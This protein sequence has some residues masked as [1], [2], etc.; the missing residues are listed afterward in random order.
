VVVKRQGAEKLIPENS[1]FSTYPQRENYLLARAYWVQEGYPLAILEETARSFSTRRHRLAPVAELEG[2]SFWNDSKGTNFHA[3]LAALETF[4]APVVWIGGGK[5]KGGDIEA[6]TG[7]AAA[8]VREAFLIGET[9]GVLASGL[10]ARGVPATLCDNLREAVASAYETA[11]HAAPSQVL[12]S[13]GFA[14]FDMFH[15][16]AERGLAFEQA[17]LSL[18]TAPSAAIAEAA[19]A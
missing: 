15:D 14:S 13:P 8:R 1:I 17:V 5:S 18:K 11:R 12:F 10:H 3:T 4:A 9:A 2:V 7:R 19:P 6:F 16:Y